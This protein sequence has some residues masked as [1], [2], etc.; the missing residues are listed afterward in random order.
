[1]SQNKYLLCLTLFSIFLG[2]FACKPKVDKPQPIRDQTEI[3]QISRIWESEMLYDDGMFFLTSDFNTVL[4]VY[5]HDSLIQS[6]PIAKAQKTGMGIRIVGELPEGLLQIDGNLIVPQSS[7]TQYFTIS[8]ENFEKS[9]PKKIL[10]TVNEE[11]GNFGILGNGVLAFSAYPVQNPNSFLLYQFDFKKG[12]IKKIHELELKN[13]AIHSFVKGYKD[14]IHVFHPYDLR[15]QRFSADGKL[16]SEVKIPQPDEFELVFRKTPHFEDPGEFFSL[17]ISQRLK[18][19]PNEILD[20][21]YEENQVYFI[22]KAFDRQ[23]T[24]RLN[25]AIYLTKI[26]FEKNNSSNLKAKHLPLGFDQKSNIFQMKTEDG[27]SIL[28]ILPIA[29]IPLDKN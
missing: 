13:P 4:K 29:E 19:T 6:I 11:F 27:K 20:C 12:K 22:T 7:P 10:L 16:L 28:E 1:M 17:S 26:D 2:V 5:M 14:E 9:R 25:T 8:K 3:D 21:Y 18:I 15:Y 24:T 23:D